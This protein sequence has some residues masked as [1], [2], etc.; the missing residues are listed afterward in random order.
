MLLDLDTLLNRSAFKY[1]FKRNT[2]LLKHVSNRNQERFNLEVKERERGDSSKLGNPLSHGV[3]W[4]KVEGLCY[5]KALKNWRSQTRSTKRSSL[6]TCINS[7]IL[8]QR[9]G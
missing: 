5:L 6:D 7:S 1:S 2:N 9:H 8:A 3:C 4:C